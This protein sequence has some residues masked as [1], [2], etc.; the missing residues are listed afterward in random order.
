MRPRSLLQ[1]PAS[2]LSPAFLR[3]LQ[4]LALTCQIPGSA[5]PEEQLPTALATLLPSR[6]SRIRA[7]AAQLTF[8][9]RPWREQRGGWRSPRGVPSGGWT[10]SLQRSE[11]SVWPGRQ[12]KQGAHGP[13]GVTGV[14]WTLAAVQL[15]ESL[16][17][18]VFIRLTLP[19]PRRQQPGQLCGNDRGPRG[20]PLSPCWPCQCP[21]VLAFCPLCWVW[22]PSTL[23]SLTPAAPPRYPVSRRLS[24][25][26]E[27]ACVLP[28]V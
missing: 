28:P 24:W 2:D 26:T 17:W 1:P 27:V 16:Q 25:V 10:S 14:G 19:R 8:V 4:D 20:C 13:W 15:L 12:G 11:R 23:G 22:S 9:Q 3:G 5:G 18:V 21:A 7:L 6:A